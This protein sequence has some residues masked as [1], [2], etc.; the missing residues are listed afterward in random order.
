MAELIGSAENRIAFT[1]NTAPGL[2]LVANGIDWVAG[3]N[4][5]VPADEFPSNFYPWSSLRRIGVEVREVP[6]HEGHAPVAAFATAVDDHTRVL[7]I[8]TVQYTTGH[9]NDLEALSQIAHHHGTLFVVDGTQSAGALSIDCDSTGIDV[10]A[11]SAH[12]WMLGPLGIG[13]V[14]SHHAR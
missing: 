13:F 9:R 2:P 3:D 1:Q 7:A 10:L 6:T 5:V 11:V 12:K 14:D 8:S 4:I